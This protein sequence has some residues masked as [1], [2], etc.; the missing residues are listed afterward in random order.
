MDSKPSDHQCNA[1][2]QIQALLVTVSREENSFGLDEGEVW[3]HSPI[4]EYKSWADP[5]EMWSEQPFIELGL[6]LPEELV[7]LWYHTSRVHLFRDI[8]YGQWGT[9][10]LDPQKSLCLTEELKNIYPEEFL[11]GDL[12]F[13]EY[14][15]DGDFIVVRCDPLQADWGHV[16][17]ALPLDF[18]K[19]W[20]K[21]SSISELIILTLAYPDAKFWEKNRISTASSTKTV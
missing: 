3:T 11:P 5:P 1:C 20:I 17:I 18:R 15:G 4:P 6:S 21:V 12:V 2:K 16:M 8:H 13:G 7:C 10:L 19:D 14:L 9:I